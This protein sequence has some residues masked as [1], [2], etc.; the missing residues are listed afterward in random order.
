LAVLVAPAPEA[1]FSPPDRPDLVFRADHRQIIRDVPEEHVIAL[2][3]AGCII[4]PAVIVA[5]AFPDR[6]SVHCLHCGAAIEP[7]PEDDPLEWLRGGHIRDFILTHRDHAE[8]LIGGW[9]DLP[10]AHRPTA[11]APSEARDAPPE[12]MGEASPPA[13]AEQ[14]HGSSLGNPLVFWAHRRRAHRR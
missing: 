7:R 6:M 10:V 5:H 3:Q 4:P 2:S 12:P 13:A 1:E 8:N 14:R 11:G 9:S